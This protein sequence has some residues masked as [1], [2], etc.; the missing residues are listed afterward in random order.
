MTENGTFII[1]GT[2]A[3]HRSR[4]S[5]GRRGAFFHSRTRPSTSRGDPV[6][7]LVGGVRVRH[8]GA[9]LRPDRPQGGSSTRR[10]F[11]RALG[12]QTNEE[13]IR[14]FYAVDR[15]NLRDGADVLERGRSLVGLRA[16]VDIQGPSASRSCQGAEDHAGG[17]RALEEGGD[18]AVRTT[19]RRSTGRSRRQRGDTSTG[20]SAAVGQRALSGARSRSPRRRAIKSI[21]I[22]FPER[23]RSGRSWRRRC[24]R[25]DPD[26]RPG[27]DRD[28]QALRPGDPP[29]EESSRSLFENMFFTPAEVRHFSRVGA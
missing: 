25:T 11:F 17:G 8:Q 15:L 21:D 12:L 27:A 19:T 24:A 4:S 10:S 26:A 20:R 23:T 2:E 9:A 7:R 14:T 16:R 6:P 13:I 22:F 18:E 3:G 29:T 5:T 1:N 28:L